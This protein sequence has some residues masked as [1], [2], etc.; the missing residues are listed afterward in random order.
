MPPPKYDISEVELKHKKALFLEKQITNFQNLNTFLLILYYVITLI[1]IYF[2]FSAYNFTM[3]LK[4]P[5]V[6]FLLILPFIMFAIQEFA[7]DNI[8]FSKNL[9]LGNP[10]EKKD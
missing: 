3:Y 4:I 8:V 10:H 9:I 7:V 6:L 1:A 5:T 2:V